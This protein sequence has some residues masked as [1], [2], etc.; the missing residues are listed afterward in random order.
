MMLRTTRR[1]DN[2]SIEV[3]PALF[4]RTDAVIEK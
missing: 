2:S 3:L 1:Q 4:S